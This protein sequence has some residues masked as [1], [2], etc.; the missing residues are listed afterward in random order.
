MKPNSEIIHA[1]SN[2]FRLLHPE[3]SQFIHQLA[4]SINE[5]IENDFA[6]LVQI[7]YRKD[8]S[9]SKLK[10]LLAEN[11]RHDSGWIIANLL[12]EREQQKIE[13]RKL[14]KG[15]DNIAEDEKW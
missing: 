2:E 1:L 8:I 6:G 15:D 9:E 4:H 14:Y 5:L 11:T 3:E 12:I 7:L 13:S 10:E